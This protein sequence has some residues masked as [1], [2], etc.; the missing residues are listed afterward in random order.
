MEP[1]ETGTSDGIA[2]MLTA[3]LLD[4]GGV[5]AEEGFRDGLK[6]LAK[7]HGLDPGRFFTAAAGLAYDTGYGSGLTDEATY[8]EAVRARTGLDGDDRE[9][10][11][12]IINRFVLRPLVVERAKQIRQAGIQVG[13]LTDQTNWLYEIDRRTPFLAQFDHVFNS[14]VLHKA[15][16]DPTIFRDVLTVMGC[17]A[18]EVL[19]IDDSLDNVTRASSQGLRSVHFTGIRQFA[20]VTARLASVSRNLPDKFSGD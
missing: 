4:F 16:R 13:L 8:W 7:I 9:F 12:L 19:F 17:A 2:S 20:A 11:E 1:E 10:R 15:K 14:Y 6:A 18:E 5:V 3:L